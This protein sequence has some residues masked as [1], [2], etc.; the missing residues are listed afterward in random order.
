MSDKT[1]CVRASVTFSLVLA[2]IFV[3]AP[4]AFCLGETEM[5]KAPAKAAN[6]KAVAKDNKKTEALEK[7]ISALKK[8]SESLKNESESLKKEAA[9]FKEKLAKMQRPVVNDIS[10]SVKKENESLSSQ[11]RGLKA[12]AGKKEAALYRELGAT[13]VKLRMHDDALSAYLKSASLN[14][15]DPLVNYQLGLLYRHEK[16]DKKKA[17]MYLKR[18][19]ALEPQAENRKEV[20]YLIRLISQ[21]TSF[22]E[23][24][25]SQI[26]W[27]VL[28]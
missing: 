8:E 27:E 20:E 4:A 14:P 1:R 12:E 26:S 7:E 15:K 5:Q 21:N 25:E 13:Y 19:L 23:A 16:A 28:R 6:E 3:F 9:A 17:V 22:A 10:D 11:L 18:Y 24:E 2:V